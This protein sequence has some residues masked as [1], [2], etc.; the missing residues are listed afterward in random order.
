MTALEG[1]TELTVEVPLQGE[2]PT[3]LNLTLADERGSVL[4]QGPLVAKE[5]EVTV[6]AAPSKPTVTLNG[7]V[8]V[9]WEEPESGGAPIEKYTVVLVGVG[10]VLLFDVPEDTT[11]FDL[12]VLDAGE[13]RVKVIASNSVGSSEP[14]TSTGF[15]VEESAEPATP[16]ETATA[17]PTPTGPTEDP[18]LTPE[19]SVTATPTDEPAEPVADRDCGTDADRFA[20]PIRDPGGYRIPGPD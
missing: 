6:P 17:E 18:G 10:G 7:V 19:P 3:A 9:S 11:S 13:Y 15:V 12:G 16:T 4:Y 5:V 1:Q 8:S 14:S 20:D 2:D